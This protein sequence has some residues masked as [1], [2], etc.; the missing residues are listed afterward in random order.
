MDNALARSLHRVVEPTHAWIYFAP[1]GQPAYADAGLKGQ[2][3][4]YFA[5]RAAA[6]GTVEASVVTA[7]FYSFAP[8][9]VARAIPDAWNLSTPERVLQARWAVAAQGMR[10]LLGDLADGPEV[11][12]AA[13]LGRAA[14][15]AADC[16]GRPLAAAHQVLPWPEEP[17][18]AVWHATAVLREHRGDGHLATLLAAGLDARESL[19]TVAAVKPAYRDFVYNFRGWT[20]EEL[21]ESLDGLRARGLVDADGKATEACVELRRHIEDETD[22]LA[23]QPYRAMGQE[24][25]ERL[26]AVLAPLAEAIKTA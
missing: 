10:R 13:E 4:G 17:H 26:Q 24:R 25:A 21:E 12:E 20:P 8:S 23:L 7:A 3:M 22:R 15:E 18:V 19:L 16:A 6:M 11:K 5:S 1:E 14:V 2:W 9:L